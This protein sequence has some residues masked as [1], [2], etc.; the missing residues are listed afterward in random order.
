MKSAY[1]PFLQ[2]IF[3]VLLAAATAAQTRDDVNRTNANK[4][5]T[6]EPKK[7]RYVNVD[8][9]RPVPVETK[10]LVRS[11]LRLRNIYATPDALAICRILNPDVYMHD[12]TLSNH[13]IILPN[14]P[15][16]PSGL[17]K[18]VKDNFK[19]ELQ[20]DQQANNA[21]SAVAATFDT[22]ANIFSGTEFSSMETDSG[23]VYGKIKRYLPALANLT[24]Q[25]AGNT[26]RTSQKTVNT[27][28]KE[29]D[30]LNKILRQT[31]AS[32]RLSNID[33]QKIY[34]LMTDINIVTYLI[35]DKKVQIDS[36]VNT[37]RILPESIYLAA[38]Y[39]IP[40]KED[41][42]ASSDDDPQKFNIYIF[43]KS[44][45]ETTGDR[46]PEMKL[47]TIS[48]VIP[49]LA[50]D[51][52]QWETIQDMASTTSASFAP[53]RFRFSIKDNRTNIVYYAT[54]DLFDAAKDPNERWTLMDLINPHPVYRLMF[55]IP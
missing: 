6:P 55:L 39:S 42:L 44:I 38:S 9:T 16:P 51:P 50:D 53:A 22:L 35:N 7:P 49:A 20:A 4:K 37:K 18:S 34:S 30:A 45:M 12:S 15:D 11:V 10:T 40:L 19:K 5:D 52:D 14:L 36:L 13:T 24:K 29:V 1:K 26:R 21:Y 48:Y 25:A 2:L 28:T 27:L 32:D 46:N 23:K 8:T 41:A 31:I 47:Y 54:A 43:R 3:F 33:M 17:R